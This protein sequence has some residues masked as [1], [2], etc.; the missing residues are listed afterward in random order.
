MVR[1][2]KL[3]GEIRR[4]GRLGQVKRRRLTNEQQETRPQGMT[5]VSGKVS[6][7]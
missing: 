6:Q 1:I 4:L 3:F 5:R 7:T 2:Y